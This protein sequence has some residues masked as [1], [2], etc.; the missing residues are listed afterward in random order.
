HANT[1]RN[2]LPANRR[3]VAIE[4]FAHDLPGRS[5]V[6]PID[7]LG[8]S[9]R[10]AEYVL[11][12]IAVESGGRFRP[13]PADTL[14]GCSTP[15]VIA[16]Y[17]ALGF[18]VL[19][20]ELASL[21]PERYRARRPWE[22]V[23]ALAAAVRR[24]QDW[25][26]DALLS[27]EVHPASLALY[28]KYELGGLLGQIFDDPLLGLDGD[29]TDTRDYSTYIGAFDRGAARKYQTVRDHV[30][31]GRIVDIGCCTGSLLRELA[32]DERLLE[33]DL[34]GI[35]AA[36]TLYQ[37]CVH[38]KEQ[39]LF[40]NPNVFFFQRNFSRAPLF[41]E[42]SVDTFLT[43]SLTHEIVSYQGPEALTGFL[44][45]LR[46][47]LALGGRLINL[48]VVG[49][50]DGGQEVLLELRA[51]DGANEDPLRDFS[52]LPARQAREALQAHLDGLSSRAR[53]T[54]FAADFRA[55][56][57]GRIAWRPERVAG[58]ELLALRLEDACEFL[59]KKDYTDNWQS[60]MHE[61]FCFFDF[62]AWRWAAEAAG[63]RVLPASRAIQNEWIVEHWWRPAARLHRRRGQGLEEL[64]YP[65]TNVLLVCENR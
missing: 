50:A 30:R 60:E 57:G 46:G 55:V 21:A 10:F 62:E 44:E 18:R 51:D 38:R 4:A 23:E 54:R 43:L 26:R 12:K 65:V 45:L 5:F 40:D 42:H 27:A 29:I 59:S 19:P 33:A 24:G 16:L 61:R 14:V 1:R 22:L 49:P 8:R 41:P 64:P 56:E 13:S 2:P 28:D 48:D 15:E 31:P 35:E 63:F 6:Y 47:Q 37:E 17:R 9:P 39:G 53:F 20:F 58:K 25:R 36:Q 3:E 52:G 34:Y 7:D 11:K 32:R